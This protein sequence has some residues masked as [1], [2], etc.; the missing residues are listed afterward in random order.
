[1]PTKIDNVRLH[2]DDTGRPTTYTPDYNP[3]PKIASGALVLA[4]CLVVATL[5][6]RMVIREKGNT[7][8]HKT[9][10]PANHK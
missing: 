7:R 3:A 4:F 8:K 2:E 6:A 1:M 10:K 9:Q 5:L